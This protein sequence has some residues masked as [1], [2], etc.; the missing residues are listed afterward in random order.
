MFLEVLANMY[1]QQRI[2]FQK[3]L[4]EITSQVNLQSR[5]SKLKEFSERM[6]DFSQKLNFMQ[7]LQNQKAPPKIEVDFTKSTGSNEGTKVNEN[8]HI[9]TELE[10]IDYLKDT[11]QQSSTV[12]NELVKPEQDNNIGTPEVDVNT[13][14]LKPVLMKLKWEKT[15]QK[16]SVSSNQI[17]IPGFSNNSFK[18]DHNFKILDLIQ[19]KQSEWDY[20]ENNYDLSDCEEDGGS[21]DKAHT[22]EYEEIHENQSNN[23]KLLIFPAFSQ[24]KDQ[25]GE[26]TLNIK[27]IAVS[28]NGKAIPLWARDLEEVSKTC[29]KQKENK[30]YLNVFGT[31]PVI[32][33]LD[34]D[35]IFGTIGIFA[36]RGTSNQ[37]ETKSG[38]EEKRKQRKKNFGVISNDDLL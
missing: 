13:D 35:K 18:K 6:N 7:T 5:I 21:N 15:D 26:Q 11:P 16:N 14:H 19:E 8:I 10:N 17:K 22:F 23:K 20:Y 33:N 34:A 1:V 3:E 28:C 4:A 2:D 24:Q 29:K 30:E 9:S 27:K 12:P 32:N 36:Q 37:W 38:V 25:N 31:L